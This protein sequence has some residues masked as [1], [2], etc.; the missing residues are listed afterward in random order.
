M[1][2]KEHELFGVHAKQFT[3][4]LNRWGK[5][6]VPGRSPVKNIRKPYLI[7]SVALNASSTGQYGITFVTLSV[8]ATEQ[9]GPWHPQ[10]TI[11]NDC[12]WWGKANINVLVTRTMAS[13]W[14]TCYAMAPFYPNT[15]FDHCN[16]SLFTLAR[17]HPL[18][19][20]HES[21]GNRYCVDEVLSKFFSQIFPCQ[22]LK[23]YGYHSPLSFLLSDIASKNQH[24][25][26]RNPRGYLT[27]MWFSIRASALWPADIKADY[28][29]S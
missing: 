12:R 4:F 15:K 25:Q 7:S 20:V 13:M 29:S 14:A 24:S 10:K 26:N 11:C 17:F 21:A 23:I 22:L 19:I 3:Y 16:R 5:R 9:S 6:Y 1:K 28:Y 8:V 2:K 27:D 18:I